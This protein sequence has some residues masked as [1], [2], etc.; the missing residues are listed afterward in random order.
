MTGT[1]TQFLKATLKKE[2]TQSNFLDVPL[3]IIKLSR[4]YTCHC[5]LLTSSTS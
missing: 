4:V 2:N 1:L 5:F 3:K